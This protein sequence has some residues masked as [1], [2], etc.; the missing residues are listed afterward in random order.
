MF[1]PFWPITSEK[2]R[3]WFD[4]EWANL[5]VWIWCG[6]KKSDVSLYVETVQVKP[7]GHLSRC[8]LAQLPYLTTSIEHA[9]QNWPAHIPQCILQGKHTFDSWIYLWEGNSTLC[10]GQTGDFNQVK[11]VPWRD[12]GGLTMLAEGNSLTDG[13]NVLAK[14]VPAQSNASMC[15]ERETHMCDC[16]ITRSEFVLMASVVDLEVSLDYLRQTQ[17]VLKCSTI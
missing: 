6:S 14:I 3:S 1:C 5:S 12:T 9:S 16:F 10:T 13:S 17:S 4:P 7:R 15:L 11:V 2:T 8:C